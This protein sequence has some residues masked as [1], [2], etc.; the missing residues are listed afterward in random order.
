[1]FAY[2]IDNV[3]HSHDGLAFGFSILGFLMM[4]LSSVN[5]FHTTPRLDLERRSSSWSCSMN[6]SMICVMFL[7]NSAC[8]AL[9]VVS[10]QHCYG[11]SCKIMN[12]AHQKYMIEYMKSNRIQTIYPPWQKRGKILTAP[13]NDWVNVPADLHNPVGHSFAAALADVIG[14]KPG[15]QFFA[16]NNNAPGIRGVKNNSNSKVS[17]VGILILNT[18]PGTDSASWFVHSVPGFPKS[19]T[20]WAFPESEYAKGHLLICFT[21]VKSA[22]DV[23]ANGL[24]LVS[25]FVYYNDISEL[26]VNSMPALKKLF[27]EGSNTFPPFST[28][29]EIATKLAGSSMPVQIFSKSQR[30]KYVWSATDMQLKSSCKISGQNILIVRNPILIGD[31]LSISERDSTNW[32]VTE[33]GNVFCQVDQ[34]YAKHKHVFLFF[35]FFIAIKKTF[36]AFRFSKT[37]ASP[38]IVPE[39]QCNQFL[40]RPLILCKIW[41]MAKHGQLNMK[42]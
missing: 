18:N 26:K 7:R 24:L 6:W 16:Y 40:K 29:Q 34:P 31:H 42:S 32:L 10:S 28:T 14:N 23:I 25:P 9:P 11:P 5:S 30:S 1:M 33:N 12:T 17:N 4:K 37:V 3:N 38:N 13:G 41:S 19:K 35:Y 21:L 2:F 15:I 8:I 39:P 20:A 36:V 27:G 22:V